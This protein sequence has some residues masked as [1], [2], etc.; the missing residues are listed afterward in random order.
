M[1]KST[2]FKLG[3]TALSATCA[4]VG[5]YLYLKNSKKSPIESFSQDF[6][7]DV[8]DGNLSDPE[9][10]NNDAEGITYKQDFVI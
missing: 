4:A 8:N 6:Y 7:D 5:A 10:L 1:R 3:V 2:K 9:N